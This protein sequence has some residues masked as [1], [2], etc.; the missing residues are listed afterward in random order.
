[1]NASSKRWEHVRAHTRACILEAAAQ[2]FE[3]SGYDHTCMHRIAEIAGYTKAT[4]YAH[5]RDKARL[6]AAVMDWHAS[7]FPLPAVQPD[8]LPEL[9]EVLAHAAL[10]IQALAHLDASRRFC[11]TLRRS[12]N[13]VAFYVE[14]WNAYLTP[15]RECVQAALVRE[16]IDLAGEHAELYLQLLL[17]ANSL[18]VATLAGTSADATLSLFHRA[19]SRPPQSH[20]NSST[21]DRGSNSGPVERVSLD[22]IARQAQPTPLHP[23]H[24]VHHHE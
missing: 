14:L 16:G 3:V 12:A 21:S 9:K 22:D 7:N 17:Q 13:G 15:Y 11:A 23:Q 8:P 20:V 6:F 18:Q 1:M 10:H 19:F 5:Y 2:A 24:G 4:L